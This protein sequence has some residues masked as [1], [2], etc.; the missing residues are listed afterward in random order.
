LNQ[1]FKLFWLMYNQVL[2]PGQ[3]TILPAYNGPVATG[4]AY[5]MKHGH[6]RGA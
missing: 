1:H 3:K 2:G 4:S 5:L 6:A